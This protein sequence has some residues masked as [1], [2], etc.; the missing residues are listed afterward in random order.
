MITLI[1]TKDPT[2]KDIS[3]FYKIF[4]DSVI[5]YRVGKK[6]IIKTIHK[7]KKKYSKTNIRDIVFCDIFF[8]HVLI[9]VVLI[10]PHR[11]GWWALRSQC[12]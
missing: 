2:K 8:I 9:C 6:F 3:I 1:Y 4:V 12:H 5:I 7:I 11:N 10:N